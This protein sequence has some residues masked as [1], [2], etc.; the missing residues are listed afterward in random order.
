M[1]L[2]LKS[3]EGRESST[4]LLRRWLRG[5]KLDH[6]HKQVTFT[7]LWDLSWTEV[8]IPSGREGKSQPWGAERA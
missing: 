7:E 3:I 1:S 6:S 2:V 5:S 4:R 8:G